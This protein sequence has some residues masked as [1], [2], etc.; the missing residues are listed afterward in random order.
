MPDTKLKELIETTYTKD[1]LHRKTMLLQEFF[2]KYFF[3]TGERPPLKDALKRFLEEVAAEPH[4]AE[5]LLALPDESL[6]HITQ[7]SFQGVLDEINKAVAHAPEAVLYVP[8]EL[9][10][11]EV[12]RLCEWFRKN[13]VSDVYLD[14]SVDGNVIGGCAFVW[15]GVYHDFSLR[16]YLEAHKTELR[17]LIRSNNEDGE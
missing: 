9:P 6:T 13:V 12:Q 5:S 7:E 14:M 16:Y 10:A 1:D 8:V 4:I 2:S 15:N 17:A 3:E 11:A